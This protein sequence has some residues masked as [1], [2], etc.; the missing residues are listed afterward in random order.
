[1]KG[2]VARLSADLVANST[3][4]ESG[5]RRANQAMSRARRSWNSDLGK[6][7]QEFGHFETGIK[8]SIGSVV[9]LR[10]QLG[11]IAAVT[12]SA[13]SVQ[14]VIQY[15]DTWKQLEGRLR[16]VSDNMGQV[17]QRQDDLFKIAQRTRQPL[18]GIASFYTRL[19]QFVPEAERAQ[20]DFLGVTESVA[21]ALAITGE[22]GASATAAMIQFTQAI[23]TN[24]ES[25]G[26]EIRSLQ[27][28]APRLTK[29]LSD[30][31]G[32]GEK[33]LKQLQKEGVL[34]RQSVLGALGSMTDE[35]RVLR[36]ELALVPLTVG[37]S[38]Q[39]LDNAFLKFIGQT[40][41][42][43]QGTGSLALGISLLAENFEILAVSVSG[44]AAV[45]GVR[46]LQS[47]GAVVASMTIA[48]ARTAAFNY[49]LGTLAFGGRAASIA[50]VGLAGATTA[51]GAAIGFLGGPVGVAI[52]GTLAL[53][54][55]ET[56][57]AARAQNMMNERLADHREAAQ[58]YIYANEERRTAIRNTTLENIQNFK[59]ELEAQR[60]LLQAYQDKRFVGRFL[61]N[62]RLPGTEGNGIRGIA[63]RGTALEKAI[64]ELESNI[65]T[66]NNLDKQGPLGGG[67]GRGSSED[68]AKA[69]EKRAKSLQKIIDGLRGESEELELQTQLYG[70]KEGAITR[71]Q[72]AL[73][74]Q[75]QL[76]REGIKLTGQ[77]QAQIEQY[78]DSIERQTDMQEEQA[79]QQRILQD[80]ER[81]RQQALNQ[82]GATIESNFEDA[83]TSGEKLSDVLQGLLDDILKI[84][85][86]VTIT[87]PLGNAVTDLFSGINIFGPSTGAGTSTGIFSAF[88][89]GV[90]SLGGSYATGI[91]YVPRDMT[92]SLHRGERVLTAQENASMDRGD[93]IVNIYDSDGNK[94]ETRRQGLDGS[95]QLDIDLA[96]AERISK[97]GSRS[98]QAVKGI[99]NQS[100][101]RR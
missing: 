85:T 8:R 42:I 18:E 21:S 91:D 38:I 47:L 70:Q 92:A 98:N 48:T 12:A 63:G 15:S 58:K 45:M 32:G 67:T 77:Q 28:Q 52:I 25:A 29:A 57:A 44:I 17:A 69:A 93:V 33:S 62:I 96:M 66:F 50:M 27:E 6:S 55:Q 68:A 99:M 30:A 20:Y 76:E 46:M 73:K 79:E 49:T 89:S 65:E 14:R 36:D 43:R 23:G 74:I 2:I 87:E 72:Q 22:S 100:R 84:L 39:R 34:T 37:Q 71:A 1:M 24:F 101:I 83:I 80:R 11:G 86:R 4:F 53:M 3:K 35:A 78:L 5:L 88:Q 95:G 97:P 31:L 90:S 19:V 61:Q 81:D 60:T 10:T 40:E 64:E 9:D 75:Q 94:R 41:A 13:L 59:K 7:R 16:I 56:V 26:Q 82:L 54:R 51:L